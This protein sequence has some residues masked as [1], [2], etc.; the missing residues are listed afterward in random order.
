MIVTNVIAGLSVHRRNG[1]SQRF[2]A[3]VPEMRWCLEPLLE[4]DGASTRVVVRY[5]FEII[6]IAVSAKGQMNN[7]F[8]QY[9][10]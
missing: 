5:N 10:L 6:L 9:S 3:S 2:G 1:L 8:V 4:T 7:I